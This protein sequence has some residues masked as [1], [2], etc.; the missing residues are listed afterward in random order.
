MND[1]SSSAPEICFVFVCQQGELELK[2]LLLAL[3][4]KRH[5]RFHAELVAA[6]P[7]G[8]AE[9]GSLVSEHWKRWRRSVSV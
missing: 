9:W 2:A 7:S 3:S 8:I 5:L 4:L 6:V 1:S